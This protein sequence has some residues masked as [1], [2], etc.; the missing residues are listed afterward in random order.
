MLG[1]TGLHPPRWVAVLCQQG[2]LLHRCFAQ[3][4][5]SCVPSVAY[6]NRSF[7][8]LLVVG[9]AVLLLR[10]AGQVQEC[11]CAGY[12]LTRSQCQ[13][14]LFEFQFQRAMLGD[15]DNVG[16]FLQQ[17][18]IVL[19]LTAARIHDLGSPVPSSATVVTWRGVLSEARSG[20]SL[21]PFAAESRSCKI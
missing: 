11:K 20:D 14:F 15:T 9:T 21:S 16:A 18:E 10:R 4:G 3:V 7:I 12:S 5:S 19:C 17:A 2:E 8:E 1:V 13:S 6:G